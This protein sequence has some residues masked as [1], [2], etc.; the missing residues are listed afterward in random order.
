MVIRIKDNIAPFIIIGL[1]SGVIFRF[2]D[3][4]QASGFI[5]SY[6]EFAKINLNLK[7]DY[8]SAF[9]EHIAPVTLS[10]SLIFIYVLATFHRIVWG[11][12]SPRGTWLTK[13]VI[14]PVA[15]F[16]SSLAVAM[17]GLLIGIAIASLGESWRYSL[18]FLI[19]CAYPVSYMFLLKAGVGFVYDDRH[20]KVTDFFIDNTPR[21]IKSRAQGVH[22]LIMAT[23]V[24]TFHSHIFVFIDYIGK[25]VIG[26]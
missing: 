26:L 24:I 7:A 23:I 20:H 22:M 8:L 18:A 14:N 13:R 11:E 15:L 19:A 1:L 21:S 25:S 4:I 16:S 3:V 6:L 17:L 10:Y 12:V 2:A 9:S 5:Q